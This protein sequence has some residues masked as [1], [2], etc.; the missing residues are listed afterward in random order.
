MNNE[1]IVRNAY[2]VAKIKDIAAWV[3]CFTEDGTFT[4]ESSGSCGQS[5][6]RNLPSSGLVRRVRPK[7]HLTFRS[8]LYQQ[9]E[10]VGGKGN[11]PGKKH[12][13][14]PTD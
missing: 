5:H 14:K 7:R 10:I 2:H 9:H 3:S 12:P 13:K 6:A 11:A 1:Q 4:D 8:R